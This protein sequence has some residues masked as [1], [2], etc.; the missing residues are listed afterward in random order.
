M[1]AYLAQNFFLSLSWTRHIDFSH[2]PT[3]AQAKQKCYNGRLSFSVPFTWEQYYSGNE[4]QAQWKGK[5]LAHACAKNSLAFFVCTVM[6]DVIDAFGKTWFR[7]WKCFPFCSAAMLWR[8]VLGGLYVIWP[9]T[10]ASSSRANLGLAKL[11]LPSSASSTWLLLRAGRPSSTTSNTRSSSQHQYL[12]VK[13]YFM[14]GFFTHFL[15]NSWIL[16]SWNGIHKRGFHPR[17]EV[18]I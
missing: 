4:N 9:M 16:N 18:F 13:A 6:F 3:K 15:L 12:K 11:K 1:P 5:K 17:S 10:N 8:T 14:P 2:I 7:P